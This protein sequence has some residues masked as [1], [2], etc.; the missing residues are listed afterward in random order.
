MPDDAPD[1][2]HYEAKYTDSG[3]TIAQSL[4][5][6]GDEPV[7]PARKTIEQRVTDNEDSSATENQEEQYE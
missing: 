3:D 6:V 4:V 5:L 7:E 2:Q 1:G